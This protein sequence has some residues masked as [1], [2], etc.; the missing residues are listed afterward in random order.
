ME[1]VETDQ[2]KSR[3]EVVA[4]RFSIAHAYQ[5][6][7]AL[8]LA[9]AVLRLI[10][11]G[12]KSFWLDEAFSV[13]MSQ[14][15]LLDLFRMVVRTDT[16]PPLY[17]LMLKIWLL[18]SQSEAWVRLPS[19]IFSI[20]S[21][22]LM[23][24]LVTSLYNDR[25][26]GLLGAAILAFSPFHIWYAQEGRMYA[27]LTFFILASACFFIRALQR[28]AVIDWVG[29]VLMTS[30]A[31]YIDNGAIWYLVTLVVFFLLSIRRYWQRAAGWLLSNLAIA[32]LYACWLPFL[33]LQTRQV[34]QSFW[35][36]PPTFKTVLGTILD[37]HSYNFPAV[38]LSLIYLATILV[39]AYIV[40][41][42][43]WQRLFASLWLFLP[44]TIS[45]LLSLRQ[46]IF[47]SRNL[48]AASL[49][50]YLLTVDTIWK[51]QTKKAILALF[52]PLLLMNLISIAHNVWFEDKEDWRDAARMVA[53]SAYGKPG[54]IV[55]FIPSFAEIPF[56]YYFNQYGHPIQT[57]GY[58]GDELLLHPK[59]KEVPSIEAMLAGRPYV[60]LVIRQGKSLDP[61][62]VNVKIWLD[63]H[64]YVRYPGFERDNIS[65]L[66]YSRWDTARNG[67]F[68][69]GP[70]SQYKVY[71][72]NIFRGEKL[73]IYIVQPG[74]SLLKIALRFQTTV[75]ALAEANSLTNPNKL[76]PGQSLIIPK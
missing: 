52:I 38:G 1:I 17:Y 44:L 24:I 36:P 68:Q 54:G 33:F 49:G 18:F 10:Q 29:Y 56:S 61:D 39:F 30:V 22:P 21:I 58:P 65:V 4:G 12:G 74:D 9:G 37:F 7:I 25:R 51:F 32:M 14:R 46:P 43:S 35:L 71:F 62:W 59:P 3:S 11:L 15:S 2:L 73:N 72:P 42:K 23:Y 16:H 6:L 34:T 64:G 20:L 41:G 28:G 63:T 19:A 55:V 75:Q 70:Q 47:L 13:S 8:M 69:R 31:L 76:V 67:Q 60:W 57:Q 53:Q 45:L 40:P 26:A 5:V 48:I 27:V 66:T 50:F